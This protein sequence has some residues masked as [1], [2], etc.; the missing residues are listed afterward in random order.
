MAFTQSDID[1][2]KS[3]MA[4][5]ELSVQFQDKSVRYRSINEMQS[6]LAMMEREVGS[7][8]ASSSRRFVSTSKG[9]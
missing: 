1:A 8:G 6:V 2:L 9:L 7:G 3:A 5:G 4:S